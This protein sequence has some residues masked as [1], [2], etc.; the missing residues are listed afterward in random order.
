MREAY[1]QV[2]P[3]V[4]GGDKRGLRVRA[5]GSRTGAKDEITA[6]LRDVSLLSYELRGLES[7]LIGPDEIATD[8]HKQEAMRIRT[9]MLLTAF[10]R[11]L[12]PR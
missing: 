11:K 4:T 6:K 5:A 10:P 2:S 12:L 7:A 9:A 3:A 8:I 1:V